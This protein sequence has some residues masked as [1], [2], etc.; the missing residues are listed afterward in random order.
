MWQSNNG[1]LASAENMA[2]KSKIQQPEY[3]T[4]QIVP[5]V[6]SCIPLGA[7]RS[8]GREMVHL[9]APKRLTTLASVMPDCS[10]L[11]AFSLRKNRSKLCWLMREGGLK[12]CMGR[13]LPTVLKMCLQL[14]HY[15]KL[16]SCKL[17]F[18]NSFFSRCFNVKEHGKMKNARMIVN[19]TW[20]TK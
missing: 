20:C 18:F 8:H 12:R 4:V 3:S 9:W 11:T 13:F 2:F 6:F 5:Q 17:L 15:A 7:R 19:K 16:C 1:R 10:A 14:V